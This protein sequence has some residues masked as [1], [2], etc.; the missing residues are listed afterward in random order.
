MDHT[1]KHPA[2]GQQFVEDG[3][4]LLDVAIQRAFHAALLEH[5]AAN[6]GVALHLAPASR[7]LI[8]LVCRRQIAQVEVGRKMTQRFTIS[9]HHLQRG[10]RGAVGVHADIGIRE[11]KPPGGIGSCM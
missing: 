9:V 7:L 10:E 11:Q 5:P 2:P 4:R 6:R 3:E 1:L 8:E